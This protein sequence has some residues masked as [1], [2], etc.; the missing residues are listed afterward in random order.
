MI[1]VEYST[2]DKIL[3]VDYTITVEIKLFHVGPR[4]NRLPNPFNSK[5][6]HYEVVQFIP[7]IR[8]ELSK[9]YLSVIDVSSM[10]VHGPRTVG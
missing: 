1:G 7:I 10:A 2:C 6:V 5:R 8:Y 4:C 3:H 9:G